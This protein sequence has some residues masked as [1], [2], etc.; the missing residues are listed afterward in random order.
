[1]IQLISD[2]LKMF[3]SWASSQPLFIQVPIGMA[4]FFVGLYL[5]AWIMGIIFLNVLRLSEKKDRRK[6]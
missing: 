3:Y 4:L 6:G 1:M 5:L 2:F